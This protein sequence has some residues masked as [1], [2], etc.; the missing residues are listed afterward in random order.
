MIDV[1][2]LDSATDR[3]KYALALAEALGSNEETTVGPTDSALIIEALRAY[4]PMIDA[5]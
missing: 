1:D 4:A 2:N 5:R 3:A